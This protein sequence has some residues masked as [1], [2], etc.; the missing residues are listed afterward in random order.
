[1][2]SLVLCVFLYKSHRSATYVDAARG[3]LLQTE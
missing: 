3:P 2:Y 1:M